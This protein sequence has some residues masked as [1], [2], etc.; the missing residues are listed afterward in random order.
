MN[1]AVR[2][3]TQARHYA[4]PP[5]ITD[6]EG[7]R[8]WLTRG[9]NFLVAVS[10]VSEEAVL[11][12]D[13]NPDEYVLIL[14]R[15]VAATVTAGND[16]VEAGEYSVTI[17]P[18]GPSSITFKNGGCVARVFS[19]EAEDLCA[20]AINAD[21]YSD[22]APEC[23]P[24][25]PWPMP[26]GGYKLRHYPLD[27]YEMGDSAAMPSRLFRSRSLMINMFEP[28][29]EPRDTEKLSPHWHDDFEQG[30]LVLDG[31]YMHHLRYPWTKKMSEWREDDHGEYGA[32]SVLIIPAGLIHTS[33]KISYGPM[34]FVDIFSPPRIDFS[35][36]PGIVLNA[37]EYPMPPEN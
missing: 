15:G 21:L 10:Q 7:S 22:G 11:A 31:T 9:A 24:L 32:P 26:E 1:A 36:K 29:D 37:D 13:D 33:R 17:I 16:Q 30:S 19:K 25:E 14:P 2:E 18:P 27:E 4:Q 20:K 28:F 3:A 35:K 5:Q 34:L 12:R 23:A 8:T 6:E